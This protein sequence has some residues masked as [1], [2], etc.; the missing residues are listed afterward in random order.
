MNEILI[1]HRIYS[2]TKSLEA[3]VFVAGDFN[4]ISHGLFKAILC[5][6]IGLVAALNTSR[7]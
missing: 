1:K 5:Q 2:Q 6:E 4:N 7:V 3:V